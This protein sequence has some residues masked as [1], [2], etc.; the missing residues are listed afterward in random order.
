MLSPYNGCS[1][2]LFAKGCS[3]REASSDYLLFY[4]GQATK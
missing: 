3:K 2:T 4:F 1:H